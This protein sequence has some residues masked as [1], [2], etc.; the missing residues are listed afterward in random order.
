[1]AAYLAVLLVTGEISVADL[2]RSAIAERVGDH[3]D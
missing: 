1:V 3:R 2:A